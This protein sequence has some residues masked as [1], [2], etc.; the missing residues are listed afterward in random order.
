M[1]RLNLVSK[2]LRQEIKLRH[3]YEVLIRAK[4]YMIVMVVFVT[5]MILSAKIILQNNYSRIVEETSLVSGGDQIY[6]SKIR[7][8]NAKFTSVEEIQNDF[9]TWS[10]LLEEIDNQANDDIVFSSIKINKDKQKVGLRG[11]AKYRDSLLSLKDGLDNSN[12]F[13]EIDFPIE[14]ILEKENINFKIEVS[15]DIKKIK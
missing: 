1:L 2:E 10:R 3:V 5:V 8:I 13:L 4:Y 9:I 7:E 15:L 11:V 12:I 14:N 6:N